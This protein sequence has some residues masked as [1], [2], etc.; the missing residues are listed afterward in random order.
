MEDLLIDIAHWIQNTPFVLWLGA[1]LYA[2][3]FVQWTHFSGL[4]IFVGMTLALDLRLVGAG[5]KISFSDLAQAA[6]FWKWA[7]LVLALIGGFLLF[8]ISATGYVQNPAFRIKIFMVL[9]VALAWNIFLQYK[10]R[11]WRNLPEPPTAARVLGFV[12]LLLW[13]TVMIAAMWIPNY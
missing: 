12:D 8:S 4:S 9:P 13:M 1:D 10:T 7:G 11:A 2:Y 5:R 6:M 3:P